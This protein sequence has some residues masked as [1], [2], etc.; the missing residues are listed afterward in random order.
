MTAFQHYELLCD[1]AGCEETFNA[2]ERR[3][4]FTRQSARLVGWVYGV[5]PPAP[6][7]GGPAKSLDYCK[8]H[9]ADLGDLAPKTLPQHARPV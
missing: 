1:H 5:V 6:N 7:K 4:D 9:A 3:A 8:A 2:G